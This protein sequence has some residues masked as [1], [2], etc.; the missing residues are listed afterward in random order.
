MSL[1]VYVGGASS[2]MERVERFIARVIAAGHRI[3]FDWCKDI[4]ESGKSANVGLTQEQR[5][6][7]WGACMRGVEDAQAVVILAPRNGRTTKGAWGEMAI[8]IARGGVPIYVGHEDDTVMTAMC[9]VVDSDDDAFA[10]L[11]EVA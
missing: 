6:E 9:T 1:H 5:F 3:T 10:A 8:C 7:A 11:S 4:R 2:D